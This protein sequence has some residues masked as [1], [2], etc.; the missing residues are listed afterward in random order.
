MMH[1]TDR[2]LSAMA[3]GLTA[4]G[5]VCVVAMM[6][7]T[8]VD[9]IARYVFN[10]PTLWAD[11]LA[12]YLLIAI[13]FL[14]LAPNVRQDAHIRID[15]LTNLVAGRVRAAL[16]VFAYGAGII[17]S[18]LLL[19]GTWTRF[20]NFYDRGIISDS[21]LM[22][23]LWVPMVP[24]VVGAAVLV[25]T[26]VV[27]FFVATTALLSGRGLPTQVPPHSKDNP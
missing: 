5:V 24:V 27:G 15:V 21:P 11:E 16:E 19:L 12:S 17:F 23:P 1:I 20:A 3:F 7:L 9:V 13:V 22:T 6:G 26:M 10:S 18:V 14:G 2:A 4:V 25:L 8:T